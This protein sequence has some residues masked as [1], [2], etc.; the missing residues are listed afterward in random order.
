MQPDTHREEAARA[1]A[2][3][4]RAARVQ[5]RRLALLAG[6]V[7]LVVVI[8]AVAARSCGDARGTGSSDST[9]SSVVGLASAAYTAEL[10]GADSVP[11]VQTQA[12]AELTLEY[13][14][15]ARQM[16]YR[17]ALTYQISNPSVA[18]ICQGLPGEYGTAVYTLFAGPP[19]EGDFKGVLAE[20]TVAEG[21]LVGRLE[22]GTIADLIALIEDGEAYVSIGNE[23]HPVDAIRG[24]IK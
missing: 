8:V 16:T 21:D 17:L 5:R 9:G 15:G 24:Q 22:G 23:R 7:V 13:D 1:R 20:G 19:K 4:L 6:V 18:T 11:A 12:A 10:T 2:L 14:A 3:R